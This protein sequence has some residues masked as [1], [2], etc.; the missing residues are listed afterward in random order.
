MSSKNIVNKEIDLIVKASYRLS[1]VEQHLI[2]LGIVTVKKTGK[3]AKPNEWVS[4]T[5]Q[6]YMDIFK[7]KDTK[8]EVY[9]QLKQAVSN[10]ADRKFVLIHKQSPATGYTRSESWSWIQGEALYKANTGIIEFVFSDKI[11]EYIKHLDKRFTQY[12]IERITGMTSIY[13]IRLYE[14]L[15]RWYNQDIKEVKLEVEYLQILFALEDAYKL[16]ADFK[17]RILD[18]AVKQINQ[19][20]DLDC[21]YTQHKTGRAVTHLLFT[22]DLKPE[23][24]AAKAAEQTAK[25]AKQSAAVKPAPQPKDNAPARGKGKGKRSTPVVVGDDDTT[26]PAD[27]QPEVLTPQQ[28]RNRQRQQAANAAIEAYIQRMKEQGK[29]PRPKELIP[30][31]TKALAEFDAMHP[32]PAAA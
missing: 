2:L 21:S 5:V 4:F 11:R 18:V 32:Q 10:L 13:P 23:A 7:P 6:D 19:H 12:P 8:T 22:F 31:Q 3:G 30:I 17:K 1:L 28:E 16:F 9:G 26:P 29:R 24:K 20:S 25:A 27:M 14:I 15:I